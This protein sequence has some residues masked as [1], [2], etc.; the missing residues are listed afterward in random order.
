M[1]AHKRNSDYHFLSL[2]FK[3]YTC[4]EHEFSCSNHKCIPLSLKCNGENDCGDNSDETDECKGK[5][6]RI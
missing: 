4:G 5:T 2:L 1:K 6:C 3:D